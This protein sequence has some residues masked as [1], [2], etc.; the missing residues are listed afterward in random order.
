M[1]VLLM[2][3]VCSLLSSFKYSKESVKLLFAK[4]SFSK[5]TAPCKKDRSCW[6]LLFHK[7]N[8]FKLLVSLGKVR[9][10]NWL[11]VQIILIRPEQL[12]RFREVRLFSEQS[13]D[14]KFTKSVKSKAPWR[15]FWLIF[16]QVI[17]FLCS[18]AYIMS[19]YS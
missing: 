8:F 18:L 2:L 3:S 12:L 11:L 4:K 14:S 13:N 17:S 15:F 7:F 9:L 10:V 5:L 6:K 16:S 1:S 19:N